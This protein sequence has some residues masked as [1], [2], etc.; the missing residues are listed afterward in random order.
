MSKVFLGLGTNLGNRESNLSAAVKKTDEQIGRVLLSSNIYET[1]PWGF[2]AENDFL[3]MVICVETDHS[4]SELLKKIGM[5]ESMLGRERNQDRYTSRVIDI[6]ILF[7][8]DLVIDEKGLKI[9]HRLMHE[10]KFVLVPLCELAADM[11]HP[12]LKK[13][14]S[15]LLEEC[16]DRSRIK[17]IYPPSPLK[18]G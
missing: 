5:I 7:Y 13:T 10:R 9:P 3:N 4:P 2:D 17:M 1:A 16:R 15:V 6:D 8:D 18:G 11:I 14:M 12:V